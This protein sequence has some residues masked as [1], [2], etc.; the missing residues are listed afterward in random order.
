MA[1]KANPALLGAFV[2]GGVALAALA[3]VVLG[4]GKFF[5]ATQGWVAYFDESIKGL[6]VGAP[7]TFRGVQVGT[8]TNIQVVI[9]RKHEKVRTPVFFVIEGDRFTE[10]GGEK[11]RFSSG[12]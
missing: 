7:V 8:V 12:A 1:R 6:S 3:L 10:R 2:I 5:R 11:F 4:G 9:D